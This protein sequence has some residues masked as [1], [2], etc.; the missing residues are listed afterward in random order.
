ME[1]YNLR[2]A[3][4]I[5]YLHKDNKI[6]NLEKTGIH[7]GKW[8]TYYHIPKGEIIYNPQNHFYVNGFKLASLDVI[9]RMKERRREPK[10]LNDII[11]IG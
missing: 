7:D 11:V 9:K 10:D 3:N 1:M 2:Q 8:L 6:I 5:D 4:D